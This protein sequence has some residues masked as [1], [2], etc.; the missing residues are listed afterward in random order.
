[1]HHQDY[2]TEQLL[3]FRIKRAS[4]AFM[5]RLNR[6]FAEAGHDVTIVQWRILKCLWH[7]DGRRQQDLADVV[8]RDKTSIT[9]MID[10][11]EKRDLVVRIPD[12]LDR[13]QKLIYLTG[14]GKR[15]RE[16]LMQ[17][18]QKTSSEAQQGIDQERLDVFGDVL[19]KIRSNL[20]N[21]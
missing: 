3:F 9:R 17:I 15:L 18:V 14:K 1:M 12:R 13:R 20:S 2:D 10:G 11:M 19:A 8:H 7:K 21:T 5:R 16:E 6:N 4:I